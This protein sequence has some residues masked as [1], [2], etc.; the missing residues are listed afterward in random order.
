MRPAPLGGADAKPMHI[1]TRYRRF[2]RRLLTQECVVAVLVL[3]VACSQT[4]SKGEHAET[5]SGAIKVDDVE[6]VSVVDSG[7]IVQYR[8]RTSIRDCKAQALEMP[9]V[10]DLVVRARLKD[11]AVQQVFLSPEQPSGRSVA[12]T[13]TKSASGEWIASAP[14]SIR[15]PAS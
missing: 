2:G 14:C 8:T 15:I 5:S 11:G 10:W 1:Q 12:M 7:L 13:F 3:S 6:D 4:V 9:Q